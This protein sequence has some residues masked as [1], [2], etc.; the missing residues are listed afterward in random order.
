M[1]GEYREN[2]V[3][4]WSKRRQM[5]G[6]MAKRAIVA[7]RMRIMGRRSRRGAILMQAER[8]IGTEQ[9]FEGAEGGHGLRLAGIGYR[10]MARGRS[11]LDDESQ[12]RDPGEKS[13]AKTS[14]PGASR[15]APACFRSILASSHARHSLASFDVTPRRSLC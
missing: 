2:D 4:G 8:H 13:G 7:A 9:R 1:T 11:E 6:G 10:P 15:A 14:V 3:A 12:D 5:A